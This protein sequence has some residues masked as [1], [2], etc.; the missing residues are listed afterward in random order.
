VEGL[1]TITG[2]K[3]TTLR[4]MAEAAADLVCAKLGLRAPCRTRETVLLPHT[5]YYELREGAA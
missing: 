2:G 3:A 4:A 5:A 1:V